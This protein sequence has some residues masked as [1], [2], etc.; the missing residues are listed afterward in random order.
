M[1]QETLT[2]KSIVE[3]DDVAGQ[4][5]D[6]IKNHKVI[7]FYGPM[8]AGKTT[9]I[10]AICKKLGVTDTVSSPTFSIINEYITSGNEVIYHFDFYRINSEEEAMDIG[11]ENYFFSGNRC[12]IEWPEKIPNL[13]SL[14][15]AKITIDSKSE[16]R[17][18]TIEV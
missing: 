5:I 18:I 10:K 8:G 1:L 9:L 4:I 6:L 16:I 11:Y 13:L 14:Q 15:H 7:A 17:H 12:F 2:C 3:L